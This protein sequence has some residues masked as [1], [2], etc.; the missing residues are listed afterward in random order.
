MHP[1]A[2]NVEKLLVFIGASVY[3]TAPFGCLSKCNTDSSGCFGYGRSRKKQLEFG[4]KLDHVMFVNH[5]LQHWVCFTRHLFNSCNFA[6]SD[7]LA[8][9]GV[10]SCTVL[11]AIL[12]KSRMHL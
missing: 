1:T 5:T 6:I 12:F 7:A 8:L 9:A 2:L 11:N 4:G 10:F 3:P